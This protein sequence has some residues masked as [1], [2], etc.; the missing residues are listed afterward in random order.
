M[1]EHT[2]VSSWLVLVIIIVCLAGTTTREMFAGM[3]LNVEPDDSQAGNLHSDG[4]F[5]AAGNKK[6]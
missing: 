1:I 6:K 4:P 5:E 3:F 2:I